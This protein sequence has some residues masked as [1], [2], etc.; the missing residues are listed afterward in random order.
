MRRGLLVLVIVACLAAACGGSDAPAP[1]GTVT[2]A[3]IHQ[4][5]GRAPGSFT[6][7]V[8]DE[9]WTFNPVQCSIGPDTDFLLTGSADDLTVTI[10]RDAVGPGIVLTNGADIEFAA[11]A[12]T[13]GLQIIGTDLSGLG[14][15]LDAT[16]PDPVP[17][18]GTFAG[19]CP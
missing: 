8:G 5:K 17:I 3:D 6:I 1:E 12:E 7:M 2:A 4:N 11:L 13:V 14:E 9:D 19:T 16:D 10:T 18:R 15:F